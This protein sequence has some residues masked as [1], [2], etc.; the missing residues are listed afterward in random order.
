MECF[1]NVE[2]LLLLGWRNHRNGRFMSFPKVD[3]YGIHAVEERTTVRFKYITVALYIGVI[4]D[5]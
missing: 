5:E 2:K 1:F 4:P 3:L